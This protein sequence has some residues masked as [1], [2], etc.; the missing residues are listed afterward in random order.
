M[1][2]NPDCLGLWGASSS[3]PVAGETGGGGV[4]SPDAAE[5]RGLGHPTT[6]GLWA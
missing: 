4:K 3:T 6:S 1:Q 5:V 2:R